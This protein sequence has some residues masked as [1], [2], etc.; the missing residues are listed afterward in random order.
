MRIALDAAG[1]DRAPEATIAGAVSALE[2]GSETGGENIEIVLVGDQ[3]R[4]E[5]LLPTPA[6]AGLK[7]YHVPHPDTSGSPSPATQAQDPASP[8][9]TALRL[10]RE[11]QVQAVV[12]AGSTGSQVLASLLELGKV[13][14][15]TRPAVAAQLPTRRG[16][17]CLIDVGASLVASPHHLVQF[18]AM[19]YVYAREVMGCTDPR[20][21]LLNVGEESYVGG[22]VVGEA[23]R[24]LEESGLNYGGYIEGRDI[25]AGKTEVIVT[26]GF[27]GN[28][29][30]KYTEGLPAMLT[31][32]AF[33]GGE[34]A[35]LKGMDF[36]I[37]GGEPLLGVNGVSVICHGAS[38]DRAISASLLKAATLV[39]LELHRKLEDFLKEHFSTYF[40]RIKYLRSFRR[41]HGR[42]GFAQPEQ[43]Q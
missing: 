16:R 8:I 20:I 41:G 30:L 12:S 32:A 26:N 15:I 33:G 7:V 5:A 35:W 21:G 14:G 10:H 40:S 27:V 22:P 17:C 11:G 37:Y 43:G 42:R 31:E 18:A 2:A 4:F 29:L 19:G 24:L 23:H 1:G 39:K 36:Q 3:S 9:R 25:P 28:I 38:D 13:P 34:P 6:P